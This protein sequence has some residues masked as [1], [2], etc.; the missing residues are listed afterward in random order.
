MPTLT[1]IAKAANVSPATVSRVL[2]GHGKGIKRKA[3]KRAMYIQKLAAEM[4]YMLEE[5]MASVPRSQKRAAFIMRDRYTSPFDF[6]FYEGAQDELVKAN[7]SLR[8]VTLGELEIR[9]N[10]LLTE[11]AFDFLIVRQV[12]AKYR[13]QVEEISDRCVWLDTNE[14]R[15]TNCIRRD[16]YQAGFDAIEHVAKA[17]YEHILYVGV[18]SG[19][20]EPHFNVIE[21]RAGTE[22]AAELH[23]IPLL[24]MELHLGQANKS[25][26]VEFCRLLSPKCCVVCTS[27]NVAEWCGTRALM[28][29][30]RPGKDF[31]LVSLCEV[32]ATK[33]IWPELSRMSYN[34]HQLG[35]QAAKMQMQRLDNPDISCSSIKVKS[36][37]I[38]GATLKAD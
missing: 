26:T 28:T 3:T 4:G 5:D 37:W 2:N 12:P 31:G 21:R 25:Q 36:S 8:I 24:Y 35:A 9:G 11:Q 7:Y 17:G 27:S 13:R 34:R 1:D 32:E 38:A 16:E 14:W 29:G 22:T 33:W 10:A 18:S 23:G 19:G 6:A 15:D 20:G 30:K